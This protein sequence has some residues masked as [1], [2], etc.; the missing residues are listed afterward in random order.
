M[1]VIQ[2]IDAEPRVLEDG[3]LC[4]PAACIAALPR[5]C[6]QLT[7]ALVPS[8]WNDPVQSLLTAQL[9]SALHQCKQR[10][11]AGLIDRL[12]QDETRGPQ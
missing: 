1:S 6:D 7:L 12:R 10:Y 3:S 4:I 9:A 11:M 5:L 8:P 2:G